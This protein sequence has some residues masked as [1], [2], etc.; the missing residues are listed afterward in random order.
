M[1]LSATAASAVSGEAVVQAALNASA[2]RILVMPFAEREPRRRSAS[3][4]RREPNSGSG[5]LPQQIA[6]GPARG[7]G[8]SHRRPR[9][10]E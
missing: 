3:S 10:M 1:A 7:A 6:I 8:T 5:I 2:R 9:P 4:G